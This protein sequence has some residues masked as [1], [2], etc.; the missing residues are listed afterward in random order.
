MS[1]SNFSQA[2][3][4]HEL[5]KYLKRS[6]KGDNF[7]SE[8][9]MRIAQI[10][11]K[12][13]KSIY[14]NAL[15]DVTNS[16]SDIDNEYLGQS[17]SGLIRAAY[18]DYT[19]LDTFFELYNPPVNKSRNYTFNEF[20]SSFGHNPNDI[21]LFP[22][23]GNSMINSGINDGD[24]AVVNIGIKPQK[25]DIAAVN[26]KNKYFIKRIGESG[27]N[28]VLISENPEFPPY[29]VLSDDRLKLIGLVT[30]IIKKMTK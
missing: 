26:I 23:T 10:A 27:G 14:E 13:D 5:I 29:K 17:V 24:T 6:S 9:V 12:I 8:K 21:V 11:D 3:L 18:T 4:Y 30:N 22:I 19:E 16:F 1:K 20:C 28:I 2:E 25:G 15:S 7:A